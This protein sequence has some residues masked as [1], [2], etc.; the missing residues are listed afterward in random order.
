MDVCIRFDDNV[1]NRV[2][3]FNNFFYKSMETIPS[4]RLARRLVTKSK[5]IINLTRFEADKKQNGVFRE[6]LEYVFGLMQVG[7]ERNQL[8]QQEL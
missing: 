6:L 1:K 5:F 2:K 7:A 3:Y 8:L 4:L